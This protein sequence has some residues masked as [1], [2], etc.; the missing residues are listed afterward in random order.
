MPE[1]EKPLNIPFPMLLP[2]GD[3]Q[4]IEINDEFSVHVP[5]VQTSSFVSAHVHVTSFFECILQSG[6]EARRTSSS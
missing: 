4:T 2:K 1:A 3:N 6:V 5:Y